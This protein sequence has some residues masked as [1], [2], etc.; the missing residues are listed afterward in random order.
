MDECKSLAGGG[1]SA[2]GWV[3]ADAAAG[4]A[5]LVAAFP[6]IAADYEFSDGV[7][8]NEWIKSPAAESSVPAR[9]SSR[10]GDGQ[11]DH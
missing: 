4:Y 6:T 2:P 7:T 3:P 10:A 8:W 11:G 1:K 5:S 9:V